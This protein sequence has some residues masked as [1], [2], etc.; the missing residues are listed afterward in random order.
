MRIVLTFALLSAAAWGQHAIGEVQGPDATVRG[1]VV[2]APTGTTV[3]SGSEIIAGASVTNL[4]LARGG[5][6]K[7]CPGSSISVTGSSNGRENLIALAA[8][9]IETHYNMNSSADTVMTP[10][11]RIVLP[12][13]GSF[14]FAIGVKGNGDTCVKSMPGASSSLIVNEVFGEGTHQVKPGDSLT[15]HKGVVEGATTSGSAESCGCPVMASV[16]PSTE[17]GFPEQQ[18]QKAAAAVA[19]GQPM[20]EV[21][22]ATP[23]VS[24][25]KNEVL[26][27][28]DA[29][30]VFRGE[31]LPLNT[32][33]LAYKTMAAIPWPPPTE[34]VVK[35]PT[36]PRPVVAKK[37]GWFQKLGSAIAGIFH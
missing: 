13:P 34:P 26:M 4:R 8:G 24:A 23:A 2:L 37:K 12:G 20:P 18:S 16:K 29:P 15:F 36:P 22:P 33:V 21:F 14:H 30:V 31:D 32:T 35:A 1:A 5:D 17:L 27:Q 28:V 25:G 3:M 19:A 7:V 6:L 10:D 11:F 9:S